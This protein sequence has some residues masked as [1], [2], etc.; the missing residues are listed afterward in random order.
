MSSSESGLGFDRK[1]G[2]RREASFG[3]SWAKH[4]GLGGT[5][6]DFNVGMYH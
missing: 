1:A 6:L 5:R 4:I 2:L 3:V